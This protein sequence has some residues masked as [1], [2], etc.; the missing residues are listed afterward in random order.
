MKEITGILLA[1]GKSSRMGGEKGL[2]LLGEFPL[3]E[4]AENALAGVCHDIIISSN[5]SGYDTRGRRV[6]A[7]VIPH[8]GPMGGI[9]S[10]LSQSHTAGNL[11]LSC[12]LPFITP[13]FMKYILNHSAGYDIVVPWMGEE[14]FEP[15]C[16]YYNRGVIEAI[17]GFIRNGNYKLP[18]LFREVRINK[19]DAA[20]IERLFGAHLFMNINSKTE[21]AAAEKLINLNNKT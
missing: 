21:L 9:W 12:D 17:D 2:Q 8:I 6:V 3:I 15:L 13:E 11:V 10:C 14:R 5:G 7:D 1:G 4:Y 18:D 19:L 16:G 20:E